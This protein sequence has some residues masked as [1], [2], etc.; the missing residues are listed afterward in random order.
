M[1]DTVPAFDPVNEQQRVQAEVT[2]LELNFDRIQTTLEALRLAINNNGGTQDGLATA[3][4]T[5]Q[6][7]VAALQALVM[8][9]PATAVTVDRTMF[10]NALQGFTGTNAQELFDFI[11]NLNL[12]QGRGFAVGFDAGFG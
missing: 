12:G 11:D 1:A 4:A 8:A 5:L 10:N 7:E 9:L 2:R 3:V 6:T